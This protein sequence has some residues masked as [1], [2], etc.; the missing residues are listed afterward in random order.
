M[1]LNWA[2]RH[3]SL[4]EEN[5]KLRRCFSIRSAKF[6]LGWLMTALACLS[7]SAQQA[8]SD[9][10][11]KT[12][13]ESVQELREQVQELRAAVAEMKSEASKYRAQSEEMRKELESMRAVPTAGTAEVPTARLQ[14][15]GTNTS[16]DQRLTS[17]EET[18]Q[19]LE[20][21][22][23]GQYQ[24][25]VE[26]A[27]KYRARIS[28][29]VLLNVFSNHG[30]VDNLD[31]P[32]YAV[33]KNIYGT[34]SNFGATLRQSELGL[35][36]FGPELAGAKTS[37]QVQLD[38][39]G[40]FPSAALDGINN[41]L[42]RLRTASVRL[43]WERTSLIAGQDNLF[44]S[45][46]SPTSFASLAIP[47][48]GYSGNLWAWT[49]QLRVERRLDV[50]NNQ[51]V[52]LQAGILDNVTG[53][54][55]YGSRRRPQAG[56]SSGQPAFALRTSWSKSLNGKPLT[57][58]ASGYYS[59]QHWGFGWEADGW[60]A[61]TDWRLPITSRIELSGEFY[62]GRAVGGLSGGIGQSVL[63]SGSQLNPT[64]LFRP[65]NSA[66]GWSQIKLSATPRLEF[67]GAVGVDNPFAADLR[68][69]A[70]PV[71]YYPS[72]LS[73]N[74]SEMTNFIFRPRSDL[75]FSGEYR[76]LRTSQIGLFSTADQINL[77]MGVLF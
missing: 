60:A 19:V 68:S 65:L 34:G 71:D 50:A 25:K 29:L 63:F 55:S 54:P 42:V 39:S 22:I 28:G 44:I 11:D 59:R 77:I 24:T 14:A 74:R 73:A 18:T 52:L 70:S 75:L 23:R 66:G 27:S 30:V 53:E 45:P 56:E 2:C 10:G 62:R 46:L 61:A 15:S 58:G 12:L 33:P 9:A 8:V 64:S 48:L 36:V 21:E 3:I 31:F 47:S 76:H 5:L 51:S 13:A 32:T 17:V 38:F 72:V 1:K 69:F 35:E 20:S 49:P 7:A 6:S 4:R 37:G 57:L 40:G 67:N 43:D 41:G 16:L 26:S